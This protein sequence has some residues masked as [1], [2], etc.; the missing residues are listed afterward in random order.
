MDNA[1]VLGGL[2]VAYMVVL[3][4]LLPMFQ[5]RRQKKQVASLKFG[6]AVIVLGGIHG[7]ITKVG[8]DGIEVEIAPKTR[9]RCL[10]NAI[11]AI[12]VR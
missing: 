3:L 6:D 10:P 9:I 4:V 1:L 5:S 7:K 11:R 2:L 12:P 8:D